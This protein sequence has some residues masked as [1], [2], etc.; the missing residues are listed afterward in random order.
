M[1][2]NDWKTKVIKMIWEFLSN[3]LII[4]NQLNLNEETRKTNKKRVIDG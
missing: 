4:K 1:A 3:F 2:Q